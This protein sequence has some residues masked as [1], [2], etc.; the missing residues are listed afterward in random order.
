VKIAVL[1]AGGL[2]GQHVVEE[3]RGHEVRAFD[4]KACDVTQL[5][6]VIGRTAGSELIVN[7]AAYTNVDGA[8]SDE[9]NAYSINALGAEN[10]A[11]AAAA[12]QGALAHVSTDFVFDGT[13]THSYDEFSTPNPKS[14]YARSKW[15]GEQLVRQVGGAYFIIRVQ[16]LYGFGGKNFS[17]KLPDLLRAQKPL[18][19]D[20]ERRVQPTWAREAA[21]QIV[22]IAISRQLGIYHVSCRG[23]TTWAGFARRLAERLGVAPYWKEVGSAALNTP[24]ER[25][26]NCL[27]QHRML[28][29]HGFDDPPTWQASLDEYVQE[30]QRKES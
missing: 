14:V 2:L 9:V 30:M 8:E 18:S 20:C 23:E 26:P 5:N 1:G 10:A 16:G 7:C 24:A 27:F 4:R 29:L 11:R 17:S 19:L 25:P 12:H 15:A 6:D 22:K 13:Q 3:L 21:R 28:A